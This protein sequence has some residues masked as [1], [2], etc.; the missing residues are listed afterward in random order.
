MLRL[1][2][3]GA[4]A[5]LLGLAAYNGAIAL[6]GW[7]NRRPALVRPPETRFRVVI[8]AHN[9]GAVI[10]RILT[11]L[12]AVAYPRDRLD[13]CVIAD[14]CTDETADIARARWRVTERND[15]EPGKG[16]ALAWYLNGEPLGNH[17]VLVV[18]DA[19]NRVP[20]DLFAR[21]SDEI[22]AG[23]DVLQAYLDVSNPDAS[24]LATASALSYWAGNRMVQ[25]ARTNLGW[26]ADLGGTGMAFTRD[27]LE[28]AGGFGT[29]LTEDQELAARLALADRPVVWLHD[30]RIYDEKPSTVEATVG[31]RSRWMAGKRAVATMYLGPLWA[32][33]LRTG[34]LRLF[35]QGLRLVQPGRSFVALLSGVATIG[36]VVTRSP[37]FLPWPI[38]AAATGAQILLPIPFLARDGVPPRYLA[39]YPLLAVL[40]SLWVPIRVIS[41]R[42]G[43]EWYHTPHGSDDQVSRLSSA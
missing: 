15:G 6:W 35:D 12:A 2:A 34:S 11:D 36:S 37:A 9:E 20:R 40:A 42:T 21:F 30:V 17:E 18:F 7:R 32:T 3:R 38:W 24:P 23:H 5:G 1:V 26:S 39:R 43:V 28:A 29:S 8:P 14:R 41:S 22:A 4:Q 16:P 25:L 33:A 31:Q 10:G 13:V 27:A 19:D